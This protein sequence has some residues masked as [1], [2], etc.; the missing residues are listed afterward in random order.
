MLA[1]QPHKLLL[2]SNINTW[3]HIPSSITVTAG[4]SYTITL[5]HMHM[6]LTDKAEPQAPETKVHTPL[7]LILRANHFAAVCQAST[8]N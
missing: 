5:V 1:T 3:Q 2:A 4:F 8:S 7:S 6:F